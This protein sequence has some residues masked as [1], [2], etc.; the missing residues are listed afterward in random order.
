MSIRTSILPALAGI[1]LFAAGPAAAD[2]PV[3]ITQAKALAGNITPGDAPGFPITLS[4]AG[5]Y[6]FGGN[7]LPSAGSNG[8]E[9]TAN[10]VSLDLNGFSLRGGGTAANGIVGDVLNIRIEG[11]AIA[12]FKKNGIST[13][14][15]VKSWTIEN[16]LVTGNGGFGIL[17]QGQALRV[18]NSNV[19]FNYDGIECFTACHIEGNT[20]LGNSDIGASMYS[21]TLLGNTIT[22]NGSYGVLG[23][24][25]LGYGNNTIL[26]NNNGGDQTSGNFRRLFPNA[27][28][29]TACP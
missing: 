10:F 18:L 12:S 20:I 14:Q 19:S 23:G 2:G 11:G 24:L 5:S 22:N 13:S 4:R 21:G 26:D 17:V 15:I 7:I 29:P 3:I 1:L 25:R 28:F 9:F 6:Q 8:I 27:C 16:M